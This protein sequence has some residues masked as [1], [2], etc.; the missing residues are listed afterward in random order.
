MEAFIIVEAVGGV[1]WKHLKLWKQQL[2]LDGS[3]AHDCLGSSPFAAEAG[4]PL[5]SQAV[6]GENSFQAGSK[7]IGRRNIL[8]R[9]R[10]TFL[11]KTDSTN[12]S[13]TPF[14]IKLHQFD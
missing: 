9:E 11:V 8:G 12:S 14:L 6:R 1:R 5:C 2:G 7:Y 4:R 10:G 3:I 13:S